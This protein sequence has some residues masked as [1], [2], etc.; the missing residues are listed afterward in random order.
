VVFSD[1]YLIGFDTFLAQESF[2]IPMLMALAWAVAAHAKRPTLG[3]YALVLTAGSLLVLTRAMFHPVW[4]VAVVA[5]LA[6]LRPPPVEARR[7]VLVSALPFVLITGVMVKNQIRFGTFSLSSWAG[8]NLSRVAVAPLGDEARE[9]LIDEGVLSPMA[10]V[11]AF[12]PYDQYAPYV[13]S[14]DADFGSR[15][16]DE[17]LKA[18]T[19]TTFFNVNF[20]YACFVPVYQQA[21]RDALAA[22]RHEPRAYA[23]SVGANAILFVSE[24]P[25]PPYL[26]GLTSGPAD[27]LRWAHRVIDLQVTTTV[28]Y[29]RLWSQRAYV[30][31]SLVPGLAIVTI[32]GMGAAWRALRRR[33]RGQDVL[34]LFVAITVAN[35]AMVSVLMDAFETTRF[36]APLDPLVYG[37][38]FGGGLELLL[39]RIAGPRAHSHES[40]EEAP[41]D[42]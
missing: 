25:G 22:I 27:V 33:T 14:C 30:Q 42:M 13:E 28:S 15:A 1:P 29:P 19:G 23:R 31:L 2:A 9:R 34:A 4:L 11:A 5:G 12:Q 17:P 16:L 6:I 3:R 40:S 32:A 35:V 26:G 24:S 39:R 41:V 38:V 37:A 8:M 21:Q 10:D 20:N 7:L 18:R 36:H